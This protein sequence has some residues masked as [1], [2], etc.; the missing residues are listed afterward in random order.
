METTPETNETIPEKEET[1]PEQ[2]EITP[3][4]PELT[5]D[6]APKKRGRPQGAPDKQRL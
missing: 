2:M 5:A 6:P 4:A 1:I 3:A